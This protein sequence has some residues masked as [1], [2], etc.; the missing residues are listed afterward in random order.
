MTTAQLE[1]LRASMT[2]RF[3]GWERDAAASFLAAAY[4]RLRLRDEARSLVKTTPSTARAAGAWTPETAAALAASALSEAGLGQEPAARFLVS[5]AG[6]DLARTFAAGIV[7]PLYAAA[8]ARAA[9]TPE[10]GGLT[11]GESAASPDLVCTRRADGFPADQDRLVL[12]TWG[13]LLDAPGCLAAEASGLPASPYVWWQVEQTGY[14]V[15]DDTRPAERSALEVERTYLGADG[16]AK[17]EFS[18]GER[19]TVRVKVKSFA[20]ESAVRD[21]VVTDL[22]PGGFVWAMPAGA[23][24]EGALECRRA[25]DRVQWA[26][27][28]LTN[29]EPL[30]FTYTVRAAYPGVYRAGSAAALSLSNPALAAQSRSAKIRITAPEEPSGTNAPQPATSPTPASAV[31]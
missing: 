30:T 9:L 16:K 1:A 20:G 22:L 17:T 27:P 25:E 6:E 8:A 5:M 26:V 23:C 13:A 14:I 29:W 24:P 28:A 10:V 11:A 18:A 21:A 3:E 7:S 2:S 31:Q 12:G 19:V 4:S 15:P